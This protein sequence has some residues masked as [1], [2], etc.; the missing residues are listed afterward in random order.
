MEIAKRLLSLATIILV[1]FLVVPCTATAY[2]AQGLE[3]DCF[4]L[5]SEDEITTGTIFPESPFCL[6]FVDGVLSGYLLGKSEFWKLCHLPDGITVGQIVSAVNE[7]LR[8]H[9]EKLDKHPASLVLEAVRHKWCLSIE[10]QNILED[11]SIV[12]LP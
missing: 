3:S 6:G 5:V 12:P 2:S 8:V 4:G 11:S 9:S 7:Y 1:V 10:E